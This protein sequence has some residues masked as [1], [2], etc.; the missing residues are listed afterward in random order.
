MGGGGSQ[1]SGCFYALA[2]EV[3]FIAFGLRLY[4]CSNSTK[5]VKIQPNKGNLLNLVLFLLT[6]NHLDPLIQVPDDGDS[7]F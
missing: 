6:P 3:E 2:Q 5:D 1:Q 4:L 7:L